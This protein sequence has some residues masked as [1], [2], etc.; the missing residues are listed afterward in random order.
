MGVGRSASQCITCSVASPSL[1]LSL[2]LSQGDLK[3]M[4]EQPAGLVWL[5]ESAFYTHSH[6]TH[7][8]T[9]THEHGHLF[10]IPYVSKLIQSCWPTHTKMHFSSASVTQGQT[11]GRSLRPTGPSSRVAMATAVFMTAPA[12]ACTS[13][14]A[15]RP[16]LPTSMAWWTSCIA[17]RSRHRPGE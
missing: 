4:V 14:G 12:G 13:T 5:P 6:L 11:P 17:M 1:Q 10:S 7:P 8:G 16:C 15:T 3:Y 9:H 2:H